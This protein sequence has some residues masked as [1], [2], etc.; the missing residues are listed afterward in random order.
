MVVDACVWIAAFL[1]KEAQHFPAAE[2]AFT[3]DYP[4]RRNARTRTRERRAP[5]PR[6]LAAKEFLTVPAPA[7]QQ[8]HSIRQVLNAF[9][10]TPFATIAERQLQRD[11]GVNLAGAALALELLDRIAE[12]ES[13]RR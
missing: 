13:H 5:E 10:T 3:P 4:G 12:L 1:P 2:L 7:A 8:R 11:L 9:T 6:G